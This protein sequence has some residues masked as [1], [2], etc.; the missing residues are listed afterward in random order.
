MREIWHMAAKDLS[1]LVRDR[2]GL[3]WLL[4]FPL[5][6]ALFFGSVMGGMGGSGGR[7]KMRLAFVDE[8]SGS[9]YAIEYRKLL[10]ES[11]A[12]SVTD[13]NMVDAR[14]SVRVGRRSA[15]I[16]L[17]PDTAAQSGLSLYP[18]GIPRFEVGID[19]SRKAE[20]AVLQGLLTQTHFSLVM[21]QFSDP[22][23]AMDMFR[24]SSETLD[25]LNVSKSGIDASQRDNL[26]EL[27]SSLESFYGKMDSIKE[28][29]A[30]SH[31][32]SDN[33]SVTDSANPDSSTATA[34]NGL[35]DSGPFQ[36]P[37]FNI[38]AVVDDRERPHSAFE[39]TFP[40]ALIWGLLGC[41]TAFALSIVT[42]K[43]HG[44][45][46]RLRLAPL[47]YTQIIGGKGLAC[48]IA[49][50]SVCA[51]L[52]AIGYVVF[53]VRIDDP[54]KLA[55]AIV[56]CAICFVGIMMV[57]SLMGKTERAVSGAGWGIMLV[58]S[59]VGGGMIPLIAMPSWMV[60]IGALSPV[61]WGITALE[62]AIWR[63]LS[64]Q[65]MLLPVGILVT[66]GVTAFFI[67]VTILSRRQM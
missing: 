18:G 17:M 10:S 42:E 36:G 62:G 56:A 45:L 5:I 12:L 24:T 13:T 44:T 52:M 21:G 40:Q 1:L 25:T 28:Q 48:F 6:M 50:I 3:F 31:S 61:R 39:I 59:M 63:G 35:A 11:N 30:D 29:V 46:V 19:P 51:I 49:A 60:E 15:Y 47:S 4:A 7:G 55:L 64:Y 20:A 34:A 67:G 38:H 54:L 26:Q 65:E 57:I 53:D 23:S 22:A 2:A 27:L 9:Q 32:F 58:F 16:A 8:T 33:D 14:Q 66:I 41:V 37:E 43:T